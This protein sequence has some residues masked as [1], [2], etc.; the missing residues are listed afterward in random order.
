ME[1]TK[2]VRLGRSSTPGAEKGRPPLKEKGAR[3]AEKKPHPNL[4]NKV[5][6]RKGGKRKWLDALK[7]ERRKSTKKR[8]GTP[9]NWPSR[10]RKEKEKVLYAF[11]P[12]KGTSPSRPSLFP[13]DKEGRMCIPSRRK[14][15]GELSPEEGKRGDFFREQKRKWQTGDCF[16]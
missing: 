10:G 16:H 7:K 3:S 4:K 9:P 8:D 15:H 5:G 11:P 13:Q 12:G 14:N 6:R 2:K 1:G